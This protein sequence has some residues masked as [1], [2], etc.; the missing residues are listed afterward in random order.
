MLQSRVET[1]LHNPSQN[2]GST[3][4]E[5][6]MGNYYLIIVIIVTYNNHYHEYYVAKF[7]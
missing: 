5:L 3:R 1:G 6:E 4:I 2:V 7:Q